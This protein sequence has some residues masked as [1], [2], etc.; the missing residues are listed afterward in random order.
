MHSSTAAAMA[1]RM[2]SLS[3]S[4]YAAT[5][6]MPATLADTTRKRFDASEHKIPSSARLPAKPRPQRVGMAL[7]KATPS[8]LKQ[9]QLSQFTRQLPAR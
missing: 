6:A 7:A 4:A 3:G 5:A 9:T 2:F 8:T 1:T